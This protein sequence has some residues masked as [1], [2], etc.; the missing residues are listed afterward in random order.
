MASLMDSADSPHAVDSTVYCA[1]WSAVGKVVSHSED[2]RFCLVDFAEDIGRRWT[3]NE[4]LVA[5]EV[6]DFSGRKRKKPARN[7]W[8]V[9]L[10][11]NR[12]A[13]AHTQAS[14]ASLVKHVSTHMTSVS[15]VKVQ[16]PFG[17]V[18]VLNRLSRSGQL[19]H[20]RVL[21]IVEER[22]YLIDPEV[23]EIIAHL[24]SLPKLTRVSRAAPTQEFPA[25]VPR[26]DDRWRD[27]YDLTVDGE[28][29]V[30]PP[31]Y[32][33]TTIHLARK[34]SLAKGRRVHSLKRV[35][36][37]E[38]YARQFLE[39]KNTLAALSARTA[40]PNDI[41]R[42]KMEELQRTRVR[43]AMEREQ[44]AEYIDTLKKAALERERVASMGR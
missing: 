37:G 33:V 17:Q 7:L 44:Y 24:R 14:C 2:G 31:H 3:S 27:V 13:T 4:A 19:Q 41:R 9:T 21:K 20:Y 40:L 34:Q 26:P 23:A 11:D 39:A 28:D 1:E 29:D 10:S 30:P 22:P 16:T 5:A 12:W 6:S 35:A 8:R 25:M 42:L 38:A 32:P 43:T 18:L 15:W 36:A